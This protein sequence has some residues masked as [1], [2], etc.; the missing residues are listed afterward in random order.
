LIGDSNG[1]VYFYDLKH[2]KCI[3]TLKNVLESA[4][5]NCIFTQKKFK[6]SD[7]SIKAICGDLVGNLKLI[8][9]KKKLF[10]NEI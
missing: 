4:V 3:K 1:G 8:L 7:F 10:F 5:I 2:K 9:L 6:K